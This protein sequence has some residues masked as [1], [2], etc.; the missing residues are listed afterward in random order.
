MQKTIDKSNLRKLALLKRASFPHDLSLKILHKILNSFEFKNANHIALYMPIKNE[1]DISG[2]LNISGKS[3]YLPRCNN[4]ELEFVKFNNI[5]S[6]KCG[7]FN[8]LEPIGEKI[9]PEILDIIY[10]PALM[11]NTLC[12]RLGYGKGYYDKF[13]AKN[14]LNAK[15]IIVVPKELICDDFI[16]EEHD[17]K[18][19]GI[20]S[21]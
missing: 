5:E 6:L 3:F 1:I 8:I 10:I 19:D 7:K 16:N 9:N 18:C 20:I 15:K 4:F 17:F 12:Y 21:A 2:L 13:F 11:A 14:N